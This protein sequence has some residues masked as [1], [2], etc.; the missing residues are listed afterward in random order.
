VIQLHPD[1]E[2]IGQFIRICRGY[3][4]LDALPGAG[5]LRLDRVVF[6]A[7]AVESRRDLLHALQAKHGGFGLPGRV[8]VPA[9]GRQLTREQSDAIIAAQRGCKAIACSDVDCCPRGLPDMW[10][11]PK[12]DY[13]YQRRMPLQDLSPVPNRRRA[14][15]FVDVA[16]VA[17]ERKVRA[18]ARLKISDSK[19]TTMVPKE[20]ARIG[21]FSPI[22]GDLRE[23]GIVA[24]RSSAPR[25]R[26][27]TPSPSQRA[28]R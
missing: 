5:R 12:V 8:L 19:T 1:R 11:N 20:S 16:L 2:P 27:S 4:Q 14:Q 6:N 21:R 22:L 17:V 3:T 10:Q 25:F 18:L 9:L 7:G 24:Q 28:H 26:T 23:I 15:H 13:L